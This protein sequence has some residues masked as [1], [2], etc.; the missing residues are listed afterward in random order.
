VAGLFLGSS[1]LGESSAQASGGHANRLIETRE[2]LSEVVADNAKEILYG[3]ER[4]KDQLEDLI[5]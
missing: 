5:P 3:L 2:S 1:Y 4:V